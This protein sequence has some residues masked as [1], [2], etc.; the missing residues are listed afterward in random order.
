MKK[1]LEN[2]GKWDKLL[3]FR[4]APTHVGLRDKKKR[5]IGDTNR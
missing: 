3:F 5:Q 2:G 4:F 1:G